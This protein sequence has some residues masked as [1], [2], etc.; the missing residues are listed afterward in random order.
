MEKTL[1]VRA[2]GK[3]PSASSVDGL[4]QNNVATSSAQT[5]SEEQ[6]PPLT[7]TSSRLLSLPIELQHAILRALLEPDL[8][9]IASF[10]KRGSEHS[11]DLRSSLQPT[12]RVDGK[13]APEKGYTSETHYSPSDISSIFRVCRHLSNELKSLLL[14]E[15]LFDLSTRMSSDPSIVLHYINFAL[16]DSARLSMQNIGLTVSLTTS[17]GFEV[18]EYAHRRICRAFS[19]VRESLPALKTA[20][21]TV[22]LQGKPEGWPEVWK[23]PISKTIISRIIDFVEAIG[24]VSQIT[25][26]VAI[27]WAAFMD[28][29]ADHSRWLRQVEETQPGKIKASYIYHNFA[30]EKSQAKSDATRRNG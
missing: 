16:A 23:H 4:E 12:I 10:L 27:P 3:T 11:Q 6:E 1:A 15:G 22:A 9:D 8:E 24:A 21:L 13:Y 19:V 18:P 5:D 20:H 30:D 25:V 28:R 26:I 14:R 2:S 17:S 7:T 29:K